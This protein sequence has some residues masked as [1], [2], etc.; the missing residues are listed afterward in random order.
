MIDL[1]LARSASAF[2]QVQKGQGS[3]SAVVWKVQVPGHEGKS[4]LAL[5]RHEKRYVLDAASHPIAVEVLTVECL[6]NGV[7]G[8][9]ACPSR[10][11]KANRLCYHGH[12]AI[13]A[14]AKAQG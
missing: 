14:V 8:Q 11:N 9:A 12:G 4:Y 7:L 6:I 10:E 5:F 1:K 2:A 3:G 13:V